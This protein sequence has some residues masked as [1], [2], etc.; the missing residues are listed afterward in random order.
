MNPA[1]SLSEAAYVRR[2][3][4]EVATN[5]LN[6][7]LGS[8]FDYCRD[9]S[10]SLEIMAVATDIQ[11]EVLDGVHTDNKV[12]PEVPFPWQSLDQMDQRAAE[13]REAFPTKLDYLQKSKDER[14]H[15]YD[16]RTS[17]P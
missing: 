3:C 12:Y 16:T 8:I 14:L 6:Y 15:T 13:F 10:L 17:V 9:H 5:Y 1:L 7:G 11:Y 2:Y 4:Y